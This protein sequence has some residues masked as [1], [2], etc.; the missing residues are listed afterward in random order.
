MVQTD[1]RAGLTYIK[2]KP[3][4]MNLSQFKNYIPKYNLNIE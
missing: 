4:N 3:E 1:I 2:S